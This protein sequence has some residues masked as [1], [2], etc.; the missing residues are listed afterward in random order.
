MTEQWGRWSVDPPAAE[1]PVP[2]E[3]VVADEPDAVEPVNEIGSDAQSYEYGSN[4]E[5][6][7]VDEPVAEHEAVAVE[8]PVA[9]VDPEPADDSDPAVAAVYAMRQRLG[10][11]EELPIQEHPARYEQL[12]TE[13]TAALGQI[14]GGA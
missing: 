14:D 3:Q 1:E 11:L 10:E 7:A 6:V 5:P 8:Q 4:D 2:A 12:H 13:L 9:E